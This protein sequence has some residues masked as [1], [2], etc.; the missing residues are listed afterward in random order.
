MENTTTKVKRP[1]FLTVLCIL[2][3]AGLGIRILRSIADSVG[4]MVTSAFSP[5]YNEVIND[6]KT[7][8][9]DVPFPVENLLASVQKLLDH[10]TTF[11]LM[12]LSMSVIAL[13]GVILMWNLKKEGFYIYAVFR[14]L[15]LLIPVIIL[16][17]N[18][19]SMM[20]ISSGIVFAI[21]FIVLYSLNLK[22][23]K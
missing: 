17:F 4:G 6:L 1:E 8:M 3:F 16:G 5:I 13:I 15:I 11:G 18:L 7:D 20:M 2:S 21:L 14:I 23:M 19:F 10:I 9:N 12:R 22:A